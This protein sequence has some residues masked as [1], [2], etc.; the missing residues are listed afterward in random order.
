MNQKGKTM[1]NVS[2]GLSKNGSGGM[3]CPSTAIHISLGV[4]VFLYN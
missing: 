2:N 1:A 4:L 3:Y